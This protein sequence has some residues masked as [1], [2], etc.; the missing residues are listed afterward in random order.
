MLKK[1]STSLF[2]LIYLSISAVSFADEVVLEI[3]S[4]S[5]VSVVET[6]PEPVVENIPEEIISDTPPV[7]DVVPPVVP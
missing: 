2:L 5:P 6:V 7:E 1:I 4:E 3:V